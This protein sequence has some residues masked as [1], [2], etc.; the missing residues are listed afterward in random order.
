VTNKRLRANLLVMKK[1]HVTELTGAELEAVFKAAVSDAWADA[2]K[3]GLSVH[4]TIGG[5]DQIVHA[6][7]HAD[8]RI[9]TPHA[10]GA[11]RSVRRKKTAA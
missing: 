9:L 7:R 11:G 10:E 8:G 5:G 1:R 6:V 3:R 4:G 2:A